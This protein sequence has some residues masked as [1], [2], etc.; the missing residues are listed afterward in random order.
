MDLVVAVVALGV[1]LAGVL[2]LL[3]VPILVAVLIN[4]EDAKAHPKRR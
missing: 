2:F 4:L 3:G 1:I